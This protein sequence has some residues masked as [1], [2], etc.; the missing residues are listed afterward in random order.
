[1]DYSICNMTQQISPSTPKLL[2]AYDIICQWI[3]Y[4]KNRFEN[5]PLLKLRK[6]LE[7]IPAIGKFHLAA[8]ILECFWKYSLNFIK[9]AGQTDGE[10]MEVLW[11]ELDKILEFIRGMSPSH[12]QEVVDDVMMDSN[13]KKLIAIVDFLTAKLD[14]ARV[15]LE[16]STK[17]LKGLTE[18][19]GEKR[20]KKWTKLERTALSPGGIGYKVYESMD[21]PSKQLTI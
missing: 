20:A 11:A 16:H 14:R 8:H 10:M 13:W 18:H 3:I 2:L 6:D 9:G 5:A 15:G 4:H 12:R 17:A 1:M 7:I 21:V 19:V